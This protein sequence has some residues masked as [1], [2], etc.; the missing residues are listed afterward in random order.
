MQR[1]VVSQ[2]LR[3]AASATGPEQVLELDYRWSA[4]DDWKDSVMR[5]KGE[6]DGKIVEIDDRVERFDTP[7]YQSAEDEREAA[8]NP[9]CPSCVFLES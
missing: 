4:S 1:D 7:Q 6:V 2:A 5:L 8:R 9:E 3:F